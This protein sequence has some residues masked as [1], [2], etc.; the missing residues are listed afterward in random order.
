MTHRGAPSASC[1]PLIQALLTMIMVAACADATGKVFEQLGATPK[2]ISPTTL[3]ANIVPIVAATVINQSVI[4]VYESGG[5]SW[6]SPISKLMTIRIGPN[7]QVVETTQVN[8]LPDCIGEVTPLQAR[9][10]S[11]CALPS[12]SGYVIAYAALESIT[13]QLSWTGISVESLKIPCRSDRDRLPS[14]RSNGQR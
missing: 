2:L 4:V 9:G 12:S 13:V 3:P 7:K 10:I 8:E 5:R 14:H 1:H 11:I 6:G